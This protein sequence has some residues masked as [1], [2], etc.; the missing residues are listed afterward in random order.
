MPAAVTRADH[1]T[2]SA[3]RGG[4][5]KTAIR[6]PQL[7]FGEKRYLSKAEVVDRGKEKRLAQSRSTHP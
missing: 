7:E 2:P 1:Y 4:N 5:R 3:E 6:A